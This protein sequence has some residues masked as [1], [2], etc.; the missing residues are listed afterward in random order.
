M[1]KIAFIMAFCLGTIGVFASTTPATPKVKITET[2]KKAEVSKATA[3]SV[4]ETKFVKVDDSWEIVVTCGNGY[5]ITI[6]CFA[7]L[8]DA[9]DYALSLP[10]L[11]VI[12][13]QN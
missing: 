7:Q 1:K 6:C 12:C 10:P 3:T 5:T 8:G 13:P 9:I 4:V 2:E 11:S